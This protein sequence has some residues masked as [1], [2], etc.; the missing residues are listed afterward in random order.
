MK[1]LIFIFFGLVATI[2]VGQSPNNYPQ[3]SL[4]Y[5]EFIGENIRGYFLSDGW[6]KD[7]INGGCN[8]GAGDNPY[9]LGS[10]SNSKSENEQGNCRFFRYRSG[11]LYTGEINDT[12]DD[13]IVFQANCFR[14][15]VQGQGV[16][17]NPDG[18]KLSE[19]N[20]I[21]GEMVGDWIYYYPKE[22]RYYRVLYLKNN[23]I[24]FLWI[25]YQTN[26]E[27]QGFHKL[28]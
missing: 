16:F 13:G 10:L 8:K 15:L 17:F 24:P 2:S 27:V 20:F 18:S 28:Q 21:D 26:G 1:H 4:M 9:L 23:P 5:E 7:T 6:R 14:G 22:N 19:G 25:E 3:D 11:K 12:L